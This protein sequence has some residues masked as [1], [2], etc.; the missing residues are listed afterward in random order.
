MQPQSDEQDVITEMRENEP[1]PFLTIPAGYAKEVSNDSA[2]IECFVE[3]CSCLISVSEDE[4][5]KMRVVDYDGDGG[6]TLKQEIRN[7]A[8]G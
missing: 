1:S 3:I 4:E 5:Y 6:D 8:D 2:R 7:S